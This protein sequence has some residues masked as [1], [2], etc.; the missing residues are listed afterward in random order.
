MNVVTLRNGKEL[1]E[2]EVKKKKIEHKKK[3]KR[4]KVWKLKYLKNMK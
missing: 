3:Q 4:S 1:N 2:L